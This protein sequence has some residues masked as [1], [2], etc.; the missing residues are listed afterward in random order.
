MQAVRFSIEFGLKGRIGL[1]S[2]PQAVDFYLRRGMRL[3]IR[4]DRAYHGLPYFEYTATEARAHLD[5]FQ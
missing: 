3:R 5:L 4:A 1:H 2:L